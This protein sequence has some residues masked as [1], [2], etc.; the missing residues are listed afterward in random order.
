MDESQ[1]CP[2]DLVPVLFWTHQFRLNQ[3]M[4]NQSSTVC[5]HQQRALLNAPVR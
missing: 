5:G 4:G 3:F 2:K 1:F